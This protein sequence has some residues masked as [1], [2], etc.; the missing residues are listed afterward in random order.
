MEAPRGR[1]GPDYRGFP[2]RPYFLDTEDIGRESGAGE[3]LEVP[4]S[5]YAGDLYRKAPWLYRIPGLRRAANLVEPRI[6]WLYP[7][8]S[9]V[10]DMLAVTYEA[11]IEGAPRC[12]RYGL[13]AAGRAAFASSPASP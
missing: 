9:A 11:R 4:M 5:L 12:R 13:F 8:R 10:G 6:R 7:A 1:G 2:R 3:L